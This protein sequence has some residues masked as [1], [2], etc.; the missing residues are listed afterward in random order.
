[1]YTIAC[2]ALVCSKTLLEN[3]ANPR[4][5]VVGYD[6]KTDLYV[7]LMFGNP[8]IANFIGTASFHM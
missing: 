3:I 1:M 8:E 4:F 2:V 6:K 5:Q 7:L